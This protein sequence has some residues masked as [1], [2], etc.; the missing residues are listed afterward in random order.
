LSFDVLKSRAFN[1]AAPAVK[2]DTF[3]FKAD[4]STPVAKPDMALFTADAYWYIVP[5]ES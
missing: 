3:A 4:A 2:P 5:A 1:A